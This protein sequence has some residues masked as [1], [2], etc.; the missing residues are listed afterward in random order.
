MYNRWIYVFLIAMILGGCTSLSGAD[1]PTPYPTEYLPTVIALTMMAGQ[2]SLPALT[3]TPT[4]Q[5]NKPATPTPTVTLSLANQTKPG[6]QETVTPTSSTPPRRLTRTPTVT[7]TPEEPLADIQVLDPGPMSKVVSPLHVSAYL[8][9]GARGIVQIDLLGEKTDNPP[10]VRKIVSFGS[11]EGMVNLAVDLDFEIS[12]VSE[13]GRLQITTKDKYGRII[14]LYSVDLV[15]LSMGEADLNPSGDLLAPI[16]IREPN[17]NTL[18]Q[19]GKVL[20]SGLARPGNDQSLI[21]DMIASD[22]TPVGPNRIVSL[23]GVPLDDDGYASFSIEVSYSVKTPTWVRLITYE[24]GGRI[25]GFMYL[26]SRE[27]LLSP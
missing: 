17:E 7:P 23:A 6:G 18:I 15:L 25:Q 2:P 11:L 21:I 14:A 16:I 22:G 13:I 9:P 27:I 5:V 3:L 20:V 10:L 8:K 4:P 19:G 1:G 26:A 24:N 12:G